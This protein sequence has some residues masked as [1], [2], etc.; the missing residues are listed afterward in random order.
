MHSEVTT[1]QKVNGWL[2]FGCSLL[3]LGP[4]ACRKHQTP[5]PPPAPTAT[6]QPAAASQAATPPAPAAAEAKP[7]A[8]DAAP[9]P[10]DA[11]PRA[12][13]GG[14]AMDSEMRA[15]TW[16]AYSADGTTLEQKALDV[17]TCK[18]SCKDAQGQE[19]WSATGCVGHMVD[20]RFLANDCERIAVFHQL[21]Q[22]AHRW[23]TMEL[24][25]VYSRAKPDYT[26]QAGGLFKK[27]SAMVSNGASYYWLAGA[28][29]RPG[30]APHYTED[31]KGVAYE[32]LDGHA[33]V[34]PLL[35][36]SKK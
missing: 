31:G 2:L 25:S 6:A 17:K 11:A 34:M 18:L 10:A 8:S 29:E 14:E 36:S 5:P 13:P 27:E 4:T 30:T 21:P 20:L 26:V 28:L 35:K 12:D 32:T 16:K 19:R 3:L 23:Q 33:Y 24:I 1:R 22:R 7:A 9:P 15:L